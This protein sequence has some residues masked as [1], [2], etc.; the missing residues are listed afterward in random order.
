MRNIFRKRGEGGLHLWR[1]APIHGLDIDEHQRNTRPERH[2]AFVVSVDQFAQICL[3]SV[4]SGA[5]QRRFRRQRRLG[6]DAWHR[7]QRLR[8]V[9]RATHRR[10][11]ISSLGKHESVVFVLV[12]ARKHLCTVLFRR[13]QL[14][15]RGPA[16]DELHARQH[17]FSVFLRCPVRGVRGRVHE[18][19]RRRRSLALLAEISASLAHATSSSLRKGVINPVGT[20]GE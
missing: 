5:R 6:I 11:F 13:G 7:T 10:R 19:L 18:A 8:R 4:R 3:G 20:E 12:R 16:L 15:S 1:Q 9:Q 2:G 17:G 14:H